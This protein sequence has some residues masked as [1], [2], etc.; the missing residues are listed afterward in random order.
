M[1][2][3]RRIRVQTLDLTGVP[4]AQRAAVRA[5]VEHAVRRAAV[6]GPAAGAGYAQAAQGAFAPAVAAALGRPAKGRVS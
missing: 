2:E 6:D 5:A 4:P 1:A 3:V